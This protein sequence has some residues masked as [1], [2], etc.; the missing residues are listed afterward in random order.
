MQ[1]VDIAIAADAEATL[2]ALIEAVRRL[3]DRG[4][5]RVFAERGARLIEASRAAAEDARVAASYAWD[6]SP[7]STAAAVRRDLGAIR[8]EDWSLV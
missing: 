7:V 3:A 4:R 6:A 8:D 5:Q 1:E 2:P